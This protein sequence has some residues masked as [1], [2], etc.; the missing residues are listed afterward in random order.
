M[1]KYQ[2][3][4]NVGMKFFFNI[5][6]PAIKNVN[7]T[8]LDVMEKWRIQHLSPNHRNSIMTDKWLNSIA[9]SIVIRI[10]LLEES[11]RRILINYF[12]Y[13]FIAINE[14]YFKK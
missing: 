2:D 13:F 10:F 7:F 11:L 6:V 14:K 1:Y 4:N 8:F 3:V 9:I 5:L 12:F